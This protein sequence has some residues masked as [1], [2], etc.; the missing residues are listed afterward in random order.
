MV[1]LAVVPAMNRWAIFARPLRD[2]PSEV[3]SV[4]VTYRFDGPADDIYAT[5]VVRR[6]HTVAFQS[7]DL[8]K[9]AADFKTQTGTKLGSRWRGERRRRLGGWVLLNR[10]AFPCHARRQF[11]SVSR[12]PLSRSAANTCPDI[13]R[14]RFF[15]VP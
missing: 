8:W 13:R 12:A 6:H 2:F 15:A 7:T 1:L 9:S 11:G 5:L 14:R 10:R 3:P 4:L